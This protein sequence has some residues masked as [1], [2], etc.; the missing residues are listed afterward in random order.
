[1]LTDKQ[2]R[3]L[4]AAGLMPIGALPFGGQALIGAARSLQVPATRFVGAGADNAAAN[5]R[6]SAQFN[7]MICV[8]R[9]AHYVKVMGRDMVGSFQTATE[10]QKKLQNWLMKFATAVTSPGPDTMAKYPLRGA[11]VVI[12]EIPGKPG[13]Y[14]CI[15][16][17][18][19]HFQLDDIAAS[20]RLMTEIAAP[21]ARR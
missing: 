9:F 3:A 16:Q 1:M 21:G 2:E 18:Q 8:S 11:S 15:I 12:N 10:I 13:V 20:F 7:S 14:G 5:A 19:P 6:L 4:V 17:L